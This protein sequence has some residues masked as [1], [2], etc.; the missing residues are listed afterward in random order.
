MSSVILFW[1]YLK[2]SFM[3]PL[4]Q[5][6]GATMEFKTTLKG[7]NTGGLDLKVFG[8]PTLIVIANAVTFIIGASTLDAQI[9]AAKGV[10]Q[11]WHIAVFVSRIVMCYRF[12]YTV[13]VS[14]L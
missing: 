14:R 6:L 7:A 11:V 9:N 13:S 2:A 1:P 8:I 5:V 3:T 10:P 12:T 4:K